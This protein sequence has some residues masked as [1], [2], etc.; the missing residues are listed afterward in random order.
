MDSKFTSGIDFYHE[1]HAEYIKKVANDTESFEFLVSQ[2]PLLI[3]CVISS[4]K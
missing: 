4:E 3:K 2:Y 1:N